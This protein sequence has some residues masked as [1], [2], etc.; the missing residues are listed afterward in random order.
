MVPKT[1]CTLSAEQIRNVT[2]AIRNVDQVGTGH[3]LELFAE[4]MG[5][6]PAA[7]RSHVDLARIGIGVGDELRDRVGWNGWI[8]HHDIRGA[9]NARDPVGG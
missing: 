3:H 4:Q 5:R 6:G 9:A 7:G 8:D 2:A 1:T